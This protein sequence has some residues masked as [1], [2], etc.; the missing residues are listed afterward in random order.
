MSELILKALHL[1]EL[2]SQKGRYPKYPLCWDTSTKS[3]KV[4]PEHELFK[5]KTLQVVA[6]L[7]LWNGN[8]LFV[9]IMGLSVPE[10]YSNTHIMISA[11]EYLYFLICGGYNYVM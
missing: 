11:T 9:I 7:G 3:L 10:S 5:W 8:N 2:F 6:I 1:N 4:T